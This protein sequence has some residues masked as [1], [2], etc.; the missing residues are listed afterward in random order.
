MVPNICLFERIIKL[1]WTIPTLSKI[2]VFFL[3]INNGTHYCY[4]SRTRDWKKISIWF[5]WWQIYKES[6]SIP[7]PAK[8]EKTYSTANFLS[9][10]RISHR[11]ISDLIPPLCINWLQTPSFSKRGNEQNTARRNGQKR[12]NE[13]HLKTGAK[14]LHSAGPSEKNWARR[15]ELFTI[16]S[17]LSCEGV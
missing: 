5:Y 2:I 7:P 11:C 1:V 6:R 12:D 3:F 16:C 13:D 14:P 8:D 17:F 4:R 9:R 15:K 10:R